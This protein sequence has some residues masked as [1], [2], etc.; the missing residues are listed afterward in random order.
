MNQAVN[1]NDILNLICVYLSPFQERFRWTDYPDFNA[2]SVI[3]PFR[4][5]PGYNAE[6]G[7][8][9][10]CGRWARCFYGRFI[11]SSIYRPAGH[12]IC[13]YFNSSDEF[14]YEHNC[15]CNCPIEHCPQSGRYRL[16][17]GI[18]ARNPSS[19]NVFWERLQFCTL[20]VELMMGFTDVVSIQFS[21]DH[22]TIDNSY[23]PFRVRN[24]EETE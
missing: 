12:W 15:G 7:H 17:R 18:Q 22:G 14:R 6:D 13:P 2:W 1:D 21:T 8:C 23:H 10:C 5:Y 16:L 24:A 19:N 20:R 11:T 9:C 3:T 4:N